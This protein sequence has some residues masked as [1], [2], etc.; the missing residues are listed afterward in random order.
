MRPWEG[1][2]ERNRLYDA[3][4]WKENKLILP[5]NILWWSWTPLNW[6]K[7]NSTG[8]KAVRERKPERYGWRVKGREDRWS[9]LESPEMQR[10]SEQVF[11]E[12]TRGAGVNWTA[13]VGSLEVCKY[14]ALFDVWRNWTDFDAQSCVDWAGEICHTH[15]HPEM[16]SL[17]SCSYWLFAFLTATCFPFRDR[18]H[19][20]IHTPFIPSIPDSACQSEVIQ[21]EE[22]CGMP[23]PGNTSVC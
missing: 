16:G 18:P 7:S 22:V 10:P 9:G 17:M 23:L 21:Q 19:T 20:H 8:L 1:K 4:Y 5:I 13:V 2:R 14:A 3:R 12:G 11:V 15:A 6:V